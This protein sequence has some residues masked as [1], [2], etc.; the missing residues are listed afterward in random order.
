M[1]TT[2]NAPA[3]PFHRALQ[4]VYRGYIDPIFYQDWR[5]FAPNPVVSDRGFLIRVRY[6]HTVSPWADITS[7]AINKKLASPLLPRKE[8]DMSNRRI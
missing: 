1:I 7:A 3:G 5:L 2:V 8:Y 4:S 6:D